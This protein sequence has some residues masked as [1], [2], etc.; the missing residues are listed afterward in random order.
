MDA[1]LPNLRHM[2]VFLECLAT[3]SVS[4]AAA[5][6]NMSQPAATQAIARLESTVGAALVLRGG[7]G[8]VATPCGTLFVRRVSAALDHLARGAREA[9]RGAGQKARPRGFDHRVT[10]AQLRALVAVSESGSFTVAAH[11]LGLSQPTVHRAARTLEQVAGLP[12]FQT[13]PVGV[14]LTPQAQA[15]ALRVKLALAE[16][17]QGFEEI[18]R[19]LGQDRGTF[20]LGSLPLAR[21]SIVPRATHAMVSTFPAVQ[22]R[23]VDGRYHELLRGLREGDLDALI[24]ALRDP[25][26]AD[27]VVQEP[28]FEDTLAVVARPG[29]PLASRAGATIDD[30]L[31]YPFVAA[32]RDTPA[33]Q[34]VFGKLRIED[35]DRT[36]VRV[37]SSSL[38]MLRGILSQGDYVSIVSRHQISV[39]VSAGLLV[40]LDIPLP[41]AASASSA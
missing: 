25:S 17:R 10:P 36:P 2:R 13:T 22:I 16:I 18:G 14:E 29:H 4:G 31:A 30:A 11:R 6:C 33:G 12:F 38:A 41:R 5:R 37:V 39:E 15:F 8:F 40:P 21:T 19:E 3:G 7:Q 20:V 34:Y 32:P 23:V 9:Q 26:P 1:A 27:D 28:V 24:G 35:R